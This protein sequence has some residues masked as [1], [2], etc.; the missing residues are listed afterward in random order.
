MK[1]IDLA[2]TPVH[3]S[4]VKDKP[5]EVLEGF[6][7]DGPSFESYL[8]DKC[9]EN[10]PGCLVMEET[11]PDSWSTWECHPVGDEL[12]IVLAGHGTFYQELEE[13]VVAIPFKAGDTI[14]NP[15]GVWHTADVESPMR[16]IYL[17]TCPDTDHKP[18][19]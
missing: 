17:T 4:T 19:T 15:K 10:E 2:K 18:R 1:P 9:T 8:A 12:V 3:L 13:K 11:S 16:A 7:F 14:H 6:N 5:F